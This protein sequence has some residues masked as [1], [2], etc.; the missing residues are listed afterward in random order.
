[1]KKRNLLNVIVGAVLVVIFLLLLFTF[2]VR[3][4]EVALVL[5]FGKPGTTPITQPG[6]YLKWP[7]PI[8]RVYRFDSRVQN[9]EDKMRQMLTADN[10]NLILTVYV[11]WKIS[12]ASVFYP[13]FVGSVPAAQDALERILATDTSSVVGKRSLSDFV[14]SDT[15]QLK[16]DEMEKAIQDRAQ[17]ELN[18]N[19]Y[20]MELEFLGFKKIELPE[21]V[22]QS[23][24][25][26]MKGERQVLISREQ[27]EGEKE[28]SI[29][30]SD[31]DRTA[32]ETIYN[33]TAMARHIQGEGEQA[34]AQVLPVFQQ[35]PELA[36]YLLRLDALRQSL[37]QQ[38]TLILDERTPP[39]DLFT[40]M[41]TNNVSQ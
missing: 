5:T 16:F 1:M 26:R 40:G 2:Q 15:K 29:I 27:H 19:T 13:K 17:R 12:D 23:V 24:F 6:L 39:F 30:R 33:A 3:Q 25:E 37:N 4:S 18:T 32:A 38:T 41:P 21:S 28:A 7:W 36:N 8:Q 11:G 14:N 22:T 10:N 31:A 34:A 20:G 35:D 9:F